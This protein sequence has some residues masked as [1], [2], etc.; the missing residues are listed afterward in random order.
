MYI[1]M[2]KRWVKMNYDDLPEW[3]LPYFDNFTGPYWSD[4]KLQGSTSRPK[5]KPLTKLDWHSRDHDSEYA[6]CDSLSCLDDADW[7]YY[8]RTRNMSLGPKIIGTMPLVGNAPLRM[9]YKLMGKNYR[10]AE[11]H[12]RKK[13]VSKNVE[14]F[15]LL[16]AKDKNRLWITLTEKEKTEYRNA[17]QRTKDMEKNLRTEYEDKKTADSEKKESEDKTQE[18]SPSDGPTVPKQPDTPI[19]TPTATPA[20]V[21]QRNYIEPNESSNYNPYAI[22]LSKIRGM[23]FKNPWFNG[24]GTGYYIRA[25]KPKKKKKNNKIHITF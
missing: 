13:M 5:K 16:S 17:I 23:P 14:E 18:T 7:D 1:F 3:Y 25:R 22:D 21:D 4:G 19:P 9:V 8:R 10:G 11:S 12:L 6:L 24:P 2:G 15:M 20:V